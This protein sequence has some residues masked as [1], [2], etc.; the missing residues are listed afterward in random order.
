MVVVA[1][2]SLKKDLGFRLENTYSQLPALFFARIHPT[3]REKTQ[4]VYLNEALARALDLN[5][6]AA[7][8]EL[9]AQIFSASELIEGRDPIATAYAGHQFGHFTMLGDGRAL[10]LGEHVTKNGERFDIQ[11]KGSGETPFSRRGDGKAALGPML[12]ECLIGEAL[13]HLGIPTT[14]ALALVQTN[15]PVYRERELQ[16][17]ILTR[18]AQSH[19]RVGTFE[20]AYA[21]SH[22]AKNTAALKVLADYAIHR[23]YPE[24]ADRDNPY[25]AFF[26][27]VA[28]RQ[29]KLIALWQSVGFIHG[30]MNTD[31]M[32]IAGESLDFGP[33]AFMDSY[34]PQ[35][36]F[37]SIDTHGRYAYHNQPRMALWNLTCF[38]ETLLPF[39]SESEDEALE[40]AKAHIE[41]FHTRFESHWQNT[42]RQK[43]GLS[44]PHEKDAELT[45]TLL[46]LMQKHQADFTNTFRFLARSI[47]G[48]PNTPPLAGTEALAIAM[49]FQSW[50]STWLKRLEAEKKPLSE[51][52]RAMNSINPAA[53]ARNQKV[54]EALEAAEKGDFAPFKTLLKGL[55]RP[56][57]ESTANL[58]LRQWDQSPMGYRTFCG[59]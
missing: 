49:D 25:V 38:A 59:T 9:L 34:D 24:C 29:A 30:V 52:A 31:N 3:K 17:A 5:L 58:A 18:V 44:A 55:E 33:C 19:L 23:H 56:F 22:H 48:L 42:M 40:I 1:E 37:S 7:P 50:H 4:L 13:F 53:I 20:Y 57:E 28:E 14:R 47:S 32:S 41:A 10:L 43:V 27:A 26:D 46:N 8:Q 36:V 16:G 11:L 35:T 6:A 54:E 45:Y 51:I 2:N 39:F 15:E 21:H 12:R